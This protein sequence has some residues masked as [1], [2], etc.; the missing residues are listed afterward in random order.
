MCSHLETQSGPLPPS[1]FVVAKAGALDGY[2][3]RVRV[4]FPQ[5][6][7]EDLLLSESTKRVWVL[8]LEAQ[9]AETGTLAQFLASLGLCVAEQDLDAESDAESDA[10]SARCGIEDEELPPGVYRDEDGNVYDEDDGSYGTVTLGSC[11]SPP[12]SPRHRVIYDSDYLY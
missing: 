9:T 5:L 6:V 3:D 8:P 12:P 4:H 11:E 7:E 2:M 10:D 1:V